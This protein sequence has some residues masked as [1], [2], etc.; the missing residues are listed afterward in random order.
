MHK[1]PSTDEE[2]IVELFKEGGSLIEQL[3]SMV[4]ATDKVIK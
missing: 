3:A 4:S 1:A 2:S